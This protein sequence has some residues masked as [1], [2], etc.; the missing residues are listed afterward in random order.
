MMSLCEAVCGFSYDLKYLYQKN[1]YGARHHLLTMCN[2]LITLKKKKDS[3]DFSGTCFSISFLGYT[4]SVQGTGLNII[5]FIKDLK[6]KTLLNLTWYKTE[7]FSE[8]INVMSI[9]L[10]GRKIRENNII[11]CVHILVMKR[12]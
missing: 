10:E 1:H 11:N 5:Q 7:W 12:I 2:I 3:F 4:V 8:R 9:I 6:Y